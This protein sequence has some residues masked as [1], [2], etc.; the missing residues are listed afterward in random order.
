ML[1]P[2]KI[3]IS[4]TFKKKKITKMSLL[5]SDLVVKLVFM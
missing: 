1:V 2:Q 3:L 5:I 4:V